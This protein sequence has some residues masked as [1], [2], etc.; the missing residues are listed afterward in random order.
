MKKMIRVL[1]HI[2]LYLEMTSNN[3]Y[4]VKC[5]TKSEISHVC[6]RANAHST[7][8]RLAGI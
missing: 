5:S 4:V 7:N 1:L 6:I 2:L 8:Q 3:V